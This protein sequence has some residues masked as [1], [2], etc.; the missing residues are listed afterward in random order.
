MTSQ[1]LSNLVL[2]LGIAA[3]PI[4][5]AVLTFWRISDDYGLGSRPRKPDHKPT[6]SGVIQSTENHVSDDA[7]KVAGLPPRTETIITNLC[8]YCGRGK[9]ERN[10]A[11]D[12]V[13]SKC[14][15]PWKPEVRTVEYEGGDS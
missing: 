2:A 8:G 3:V 4:A 1:E 15:A 5:L 9:K 12:E 10:I 6:I 13:C 7:R 14:G 11:N